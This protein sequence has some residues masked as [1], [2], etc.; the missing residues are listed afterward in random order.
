MERKQKEHETEELERKTREFQQAEKEKLSH[1]SPDLQR[2][3]GELQDNQKRLLADE[4]KLRGIFN[5]VCMQLS[6]YEE[7]VNANSKKQQL[8]KLHA[9]KTALQERVSKL[10]AEVNKPV[11][12]EAEMRE[13]LLEQVK[14]DKESTATYERNSATLE[15]RIKQAEEELEK[16]ESGGST[17]DAED[18]KKYQKLQEKDQEMSDFIAK[19]EETMQKEREAI[20]VTEHRVVQLLEHISKDLGRSQQL[21]DKEGYLNMQN[22]VAMKQRGLDNSQTTAERLKS[23]QTMRQAEL[24]KIENLDQKISIELKTLNDRRETM[25]E[26][27][28]KFGNISQLREDAEQVLPHAH[29]LEHADTPK[30]KGAS[31][32]KCHVHAH[33]RVKSALRVASVRQ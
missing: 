26:E 1:L 14:K 15:Q 22:E 18:A 28:K 10:E 27:L 25:T 13:H 17:A 6:E 2:K 11:L 7:Q 29:A 21:P 16:L 12:S 4:D 31:V 33:A 24:D 19:H 5:N 23:E 3:Y 32:G 9:N 30:G 8:I 20:K